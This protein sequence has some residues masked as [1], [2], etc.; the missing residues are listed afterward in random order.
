MEEVNSNSENL[1]GKFL[2]SKRARKKKTGP[3]IDYVK[4][5]KKKK[6]KELVKEKGKSMTQRK[7]RFVGE[8]ETVSVF[9]TKD[10]IYTDKQILDCFRRNLGIQSKTCKE[11]GIHEFTFISWRKRYPK[12]GEEVELIKNQIKDIVEDKLIEKTREG[13]TQ[14]L[15]YMARNLLKDRGYTE[16]TIQANTQI[17]IVMPED[18]NKKYEWWGNK[19]NKNVASS[20][21]SGSILDPEKV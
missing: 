1:T 4:R 11:L 21:T 7:I 18:M 12:F 10:P 6:Y 15:L 14:I 13:D 3:K 9:K 16:E 20:E 8:G 17:N 5:H 19:D 2:V